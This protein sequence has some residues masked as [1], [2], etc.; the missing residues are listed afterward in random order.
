V[1]RSL[2]V[3]VTAPVG[4]QPAVP[5]RLVWQ[6]VSSA[7]HYRVRLTEVDRHELW[8]ADAVTAAIDLPPAVRAQIVPGKTL[9]WQVTAYGPA[10]EPIGESEPQ[11][12]RLTR[13]P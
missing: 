13:S 3:I 12:F 5:E 8:A 7:Q 1:T 9:L 11:R 2:G 6:P 10:N 4:D